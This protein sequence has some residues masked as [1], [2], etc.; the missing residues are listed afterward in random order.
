ML[1]LILKKHGMKCYLYEASPEP[2][3]TGTGIFIWTQG[4]KVLESVFPREQLE[5]ISQK[6]NCFNVLNQHMN[7]IH[8]KDIAE[9][10]NIKETAAYMFHRKKTL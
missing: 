2:R 9:K 1:A 4:M 6:V 7:L 5:E 10:A 3:V 8:H